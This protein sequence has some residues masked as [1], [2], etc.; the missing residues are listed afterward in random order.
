MSRTGCGSFVPNDLWFPACLMGLYKRGH[1]LP[2]GSLYWAVIC[3]LRRGYTACHLA[4]IIKHFCFFYIYVLAQEMFP[5]SKVKN[6]FCLGR[7]MRNQRM[8]WVSLLNHKF[9]SGDDVRALSCSSFCSEKAENRIRHK[10]FEVFTKAPVEPVAPIL[11][12]GA[13]SACNP[14]S[15]FHASK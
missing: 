5:K 4:L 15:G 10:L 2:L 9:H 1:S 7:G 13:T 3:L 6:S 12:L 8:K 11:S 14:N